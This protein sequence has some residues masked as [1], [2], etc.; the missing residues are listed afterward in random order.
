MRWLYLMSNLIRHPRPCPSTILDCVQVQLNQDG[1]I[2]IK[3]SPS[4]EIAPEISLNSSALEDTSSPTNTTADIE[5]IPSDE[6][7]IKADESSLELTTPTGN[8]VDLETTANEVSVVR[9]MFKAL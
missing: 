9:E 3:E 6:L 1:K 4:I 8:N 5:L 7:A 2:E